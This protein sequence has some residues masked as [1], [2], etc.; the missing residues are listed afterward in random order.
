MAATAIT[1]DTGLAAFLRDEALMPT[2]A[3]GAE[4]HTD[5]VAAHAVIAAVRAAVPVA[6]M[7][8]AT[9]EAM[10]AAL[11]E[12]MLVALVAAMQAA[13]AAAAAMQAVAAA[14]AAAGIGKHMRL[15]SER[16]VCFGRRAFL[17]RMPMLDDP[18]GLPAHCLTST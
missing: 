8:A 2:V 15:S 7:Q 10:R 11:A 5:T 12:A 17:A 13:L 9:A 14:M 4:L 6:V 1:A 18:L 16:L 3:I